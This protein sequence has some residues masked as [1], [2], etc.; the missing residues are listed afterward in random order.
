[1]DDNEAEFN[2]PM[3]IGLEVLLSPLGLGV[4][5]GGGLNRITRGTISSN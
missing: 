1:M 5:A 3:R 2:V 4:R